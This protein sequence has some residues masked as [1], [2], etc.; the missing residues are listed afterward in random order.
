MDNQI[1]YVPSNLNVR[2]S[3]KAGTHPTVVYQN[4]HYWWSEDNKQSTRYNCVEKS[5]KKCSGS[6][7]IAQDKVTRSTGHTAHTCMTD[8]QVKILIKGQEFKKKN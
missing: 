3:T 7:T 8:N 4:F 2:N 1:L 6:I 5:T